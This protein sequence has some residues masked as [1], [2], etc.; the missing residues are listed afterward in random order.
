MVNRK[1]KEVI[2]PSCASLV[3]PLTLV[4]GAYIILH[5]HL[6]PGGGFQGGVLIA[7]ALTI[8]FLAFGKEKTLETFH[9][10]RFSYSE[11]IGALAFLLFAT[12][13]VIYGTSF[14]SNVVAKG[15]L[16][17][18]F[19]SGTVFLMNFAVGYKVL[20]G[21]GVLILVMIGTLKGDNEEGLEDGD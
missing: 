1:C 15:S 7:G 21:I 12:L 18:L 10:K 9:L 16:G 3:M 13:G 4:L 11:D 14:C 2:V 20:A 17:K 5:G 8:F 6:S 19:S